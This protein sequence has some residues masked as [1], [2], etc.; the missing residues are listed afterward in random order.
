MSLM[1][2]FQKSLSFATFSLNSVPVTAGNR[3][4]AEQFQGAANGKL[5]TVV[6]D[7]LPLASASEAHDRMDKGAVFGRFVLIP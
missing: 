7:V 3:V 2:A 1:R 5:R 6:H 4:L